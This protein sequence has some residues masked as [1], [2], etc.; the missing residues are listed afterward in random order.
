MKMKMNKKTVCVC[1]IVL[2]ILFVCLV[3]YMSINKKGLKE[4][5]EE[6][7]VGSTAL[8]Q[9]IDPTET[10]A[11]GKL[12]YTYIGPT[13]TGVNSSLPQYLVNL[14]EN[15]NGTY[16]FYM[17]PQN[18]ANSHYLQ[19]LVGGENLF[20]TD[21]AKANKLK[22]GIETNAV[23]LVYNEIN[24]KN[25]GQI[26]TCNIGNKSYIL[27]T[28]GTTTYLSS[29]EKTVLSPP[30][31]ESV[32][33]E[34]SHISTPTPTPMPM[35]TLKS[36]STSTPHPTKRSSRDPNPNYTGL[37]PMEGINI[38]VHY[39]GDETFTFTM[40]NTF[41]LKGT[42]NLVGDNPALAKKLLSTA[43]VKKPYVTTY[44]ESPVG[45][46]PGKILLSY[47]EGNIYGLYSPTG[48]IHV[49]PD[50]YISLLQQV[51][52]QNQTQNQNQ[53]NTY[54]N[55]NHY[56][57][58]ATP[59]VFHGP[60]DSTAIVTTQNNTA[61]IIV[62]DANGNNVVYKINTNEYQGKTTQ[63][64]GSN[65]H[66]YTEQIYY[67]P[68]GGYAVLLTDQTNN[69]QYITVVF[70]D[71]SKMEYMTKSNNTNDPDL[72]QNMTYKQLAA[73]SEAYLNGNYF[74]KNVKH[75]H[76]HHKHKKHHPD[77][78]WDSDSDDDSGSN[79]GYNYNDYLPKGISRSMIPPG[80]ED[81]YIL[82]TEVVPP[83]C[84]ACP[85]CPSCPGCPACSVPSV[86]EP[87][88]AQYPDSSSHGKGHG[89]GQGHGQGE[90]PNFIPFAT[91]NQSQNQI[92][93]PML[94]SF[95]SF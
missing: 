37:P 78:G 91:Q 5:L 12:D 95:S 81:L 3:V 41:V 34:A 42:T 19:K 39:N 13:Y 32:W 14:T 40:N 48:I 84:P 11:I 58:T 29:F 25:G 22:L 64:N 88:P 35:P 50:V 56:S 16:T 82:K 85:R 47:Y 71:G 44:V 24:A 21:P 73:N 38:T 63:L 68:N 2:S 72:P 45:S 1:L 74:S 20:K 27:L 31:T 76:H 53:N 46:G 43:F 17:K 33:P 57:G 36:L 89:Q 59:T 83:I 8:Y 51:N 62:K 69:H 61:I 10:A 66:K 55:Y 86:P 4:G 87:A 60:N 49:G 79:P 26:K 77:P 92:P 6:K 54:D 18:D 80:D 28:S 75:K 70:P 90:K 67:G 15:K 93:I 65:K 30:S 23:T 94:N 52:N 7:N 9:A